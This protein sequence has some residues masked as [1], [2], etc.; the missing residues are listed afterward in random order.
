MIKKRTRNGS[1]HNK[2]V[3]VQKENIKKYIKRA[4]KF[5]K[6]LKK[7]QHKEKR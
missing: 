4:K 6:S 5:F 1:F 7:W 2:K 3:S